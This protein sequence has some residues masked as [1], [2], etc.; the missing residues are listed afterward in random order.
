MPLLE[1]RLLLAVNGVFSRR[2]LSKGRLLM[3]VVY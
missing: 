1:Q 2:P 3:P